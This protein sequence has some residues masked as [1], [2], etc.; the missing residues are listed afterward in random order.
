MSH[1]AIISV[2]DKGNNN[3]PNKDPSRKP[4]AVPLLYLSQQ[5]KVTFGDPKS[6]PHFATSSFQPNASESGSGSG[7]AGEG[8]GPGSKHLSSS[9]TNIPKVKHSVNSLIS[10]LGL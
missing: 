5:R 4:E 3:N 10:I 6:G 7:Q 1:E 2:I 8:G 9:T